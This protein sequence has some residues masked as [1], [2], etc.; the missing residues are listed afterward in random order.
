VSEAAPERG[1]GNVLTRKFG[2]LPGWAWLGLVVGGAAVVIYIRRKKAATTASSTTA[3]ASSGCTDANGNPVDCGSTAAVSDIGTNGY[4][5]LYTQGQGIQDSLT[6]IQALLAGTQGAATTSGGDV[7][8][9]TSSGSTTGTS[10][11]T[12]APGSGGGVSQYSAPGNLNVHPD[13]AT[14]IAVQWT[15]STPPAMSYTIAVYQLNGR[16]VG[17]PHVVLA[18]PNQ[19]TI[20]SAVSGLTPKYQYNVHVWA[21]GGTSAP[22]HASASV[23]M[24]AK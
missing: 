3:A 21:N 18:T 9:T 15:P 13:N 7:T 8:G 1:G 22:P 23:T 5:A 19:Q 10:G 12:P 14:T 6:N 17:G 24:P 16:Q 4:E 2:P 20:T 11:G